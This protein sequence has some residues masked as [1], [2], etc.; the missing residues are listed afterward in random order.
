MGLLSRAVESV[1]GSDGSEESFRYRCV[2]CEAVFE[3][4]KTRMVGI[5]CPDCGSMDVRIAD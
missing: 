2:E 5:T 3:F 4:P 1:L